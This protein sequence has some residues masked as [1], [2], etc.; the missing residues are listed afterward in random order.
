MTCWCYVETHLTGKT[1][2]LQSISGPSF[3]CK[4]SR[5]R[6]A[7]CMAMVIYSLVPPLPVPVPQRPLITSSPNC[8][9]QGYPLF[10]SFLNICCVEL[11]PGFVISLEFSK[12]ITYL[13]YSNQS[14]HPNFKGMNI[15]AAPTFLLFHSH[16]HDVRK[17]LF[18]V[19]THCYIRSFILVCLSLYNMHFALP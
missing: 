19:F 12:L 14:S 5:N 6:L 7:S 1:H 13:H 10:R 4:L 15:L 11:V 17:T 9:Q 3:G 8:W 2:F 16:V 18:V